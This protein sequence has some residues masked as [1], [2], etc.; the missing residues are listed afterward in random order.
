MTLAAKPNLSHK[1]KYTAYPFG[2]KVKFGPDLVGEIVET[3][4]VGPAAQ[5]AYL[6]EWW[7][8]EGSVRQIDLYEE[9]IR[10]VR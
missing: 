10:I 8:S 5:A 6:V 4:F 3:K 2:T 1:V 7:D 9:R